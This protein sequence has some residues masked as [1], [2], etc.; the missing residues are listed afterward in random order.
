MENKIVHTALENLKLHTGI[1]GLFH[2]KSQ[3]GTEGE[4]VLLFDKGKE[5]FVVEIKREIRSHQLEHIRQRASG[6][7]NYLLIVETLF[8]KIREELRKSAIG[9]LDSAG[10]IFIHSDAHHLWVEGLKIKTNKEGKTHRAFSVAGLKVIFLF[11]ADDKLLN[12]P[13]RSIAEQ[14]GVALGNINY[15][16]NGLAEH[17]FLLKKNKKEYQLI[18]LKQLMEKWMAG[19]EEKLKPALHLG[20]FKFLKSEDAEYWKLLALKP[21]HTFWGGEPAGALLTGYLFPATFDIYTDEPISDLI[22]KYRLIPDPSGKVAVYK[23]FWQGEHSFDHTVVHPLLVYAD[24][25]HSGDRRCAETA[26]KIY[27]ELLH[28]RF[29]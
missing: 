7:K 1:E 9:Y 27:D 10:N 14:A 20:N 21:G 3:K 2:A 15:V 22:K 5:A 6:N 28:H 16:I 17:Q 29:S 4:V 11:L 12:L 18:H 13:Q 8:P 24:L 19:F 23:K 25:L 26:Q